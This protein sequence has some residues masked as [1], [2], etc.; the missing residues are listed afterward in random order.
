M[1]REAIILAGGLGTRLQSVLPDIPKCMAPIGDNP[2]LSYSIALLQKMGIERFIFSL[3]Y[4]YEMIQ[5]FVTSHYPQL[6]VA[7]AIEKQALGTGGAI[8]KACSLASGKTV[9][10]VNGDTYF[11]IGLP[12]MEA[13]HHLCG[14]QCTL[15]L[16]P[17]RNFDRYGVVELGEDYSIKGFKEKHF[18]ESGLINGGVYLLHAA[19]FLEEN[20]PDKF[21]FEKDYLEKFYPVRPFYGVVQDAYFIDIG[22]PEDFALAQ[23]ELPKQI[24]I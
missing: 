2:F 18:Y 20:L 13:F 11:D 10:V 22:I 14:S 5:E 17:M 1:A 16:K 21:S 24:K 8:R 19:R 15:A 3:G 4:R 9:L 6:P 12:A 23:V 7:Y